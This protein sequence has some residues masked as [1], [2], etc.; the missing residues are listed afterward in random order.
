M[1]K[2]FKNLI[3]PQAVLYGSILIAEAGNVFQLPKL[4][5]DAK[6]CL[7]KAKESIFSVTESEAQV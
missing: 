7:P 5:S 6:H 4:L 1:L 3:F 2:L